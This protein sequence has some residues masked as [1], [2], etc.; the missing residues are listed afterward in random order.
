MQHL[1]YPE[2]THY[3]H[4]KNFDF[5]IF[6]ATDSFSENHKYGASL[7]L[8]G[9]SWSMVGIIP[10]EV[11]RDLLAHYQKAGLEAELLETDSSETIPGEKAIKVGSRK[12]DLV[13]LKFASG[14]IGAGRGFSIGPTISKQV[15][16]MGP[17]NINFHYIVK[18][19]GKL[20]ENDLKAE[21]KEKK[22]AWFPKNSLTSSGKGESWQ[23]Y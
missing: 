12:F 19:I 4:G 1:P 22:K 10:K 7:F 15:T 8:D 21:V 11:F 14:T 17:S 18:G 9:D 6:R 16:K 3:V 20:D 5:L 2:K 13:I 23:G